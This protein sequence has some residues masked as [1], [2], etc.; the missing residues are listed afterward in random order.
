MAK[1]N[2]LEARAARAERALQTVKKKGAQAAKST[3]RV[4]TVNGAAFLAGV[5]DRK[6]SEDGAELKLGRVPLVPALGIAAGLAGL[7]NA[8]NA[9]TAAML[10]DVSFGLTAPWFYNQGKVAADSMALPKA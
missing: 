1:Q 4:A 9:K 2:K 10:M 8:P 5:L 3:R 7:M 6:F